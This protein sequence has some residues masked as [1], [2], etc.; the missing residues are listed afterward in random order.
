MSLTVQQRAERVGYLGGTDAAAV[1]GL[2]RY[3]T[4]L[5][6]W[7]EK[8]GAIIKNGKNDGDL[9][10]WMGN[11]LEDVIAERFSFETGLKVRRV[12]E[13]QTH[14]KYPF[15]RAQIDRRVV[16]SDEIL[17]C[18][19]ASA[20]KGFEW[21][22]DDVPSEY[23]LQAMHQL[24]VTGAERCHM[25]CL[26]GGNVDFVRK[27]IERDRDMIA[28]LEDREV[29]FWNENVLA[30]QIPKVTA[31]DQSTLAALFPVGRED[32]EPID[33]PQGMEAIAE[34]IKELGSDTTGLISVLK[35]EKD[36]LQN[37]LRLALGESSLGVVGNW[38]VSW[39]NQDKTTIDGTILAAENP[40]LFAKC[41]VTKSTRVLRISDVSKKK[42][43]K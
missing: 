40:G 18:K 21:E 32:D 12:T 4:P 2:S 13:V 38:K 42:G 28:E 17:E 43:A 26:I 3:K 37:E 34:R 41:A 23:I 35:K 25:A 5:A 20:Y 36:E 9:P 8:T 30:R 31:Y 11:R 15:L 22:G 29:K 27:V 19:S 14:K 1:L 39:K 24:M 16:G 7:S 33:L 6:L 10:I